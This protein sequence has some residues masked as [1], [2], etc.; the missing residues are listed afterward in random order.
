M[1][2]DAQG[3]VQARPIHGPADWPR[4]VEELGKME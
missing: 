3:A 1:I 2:H 4:A